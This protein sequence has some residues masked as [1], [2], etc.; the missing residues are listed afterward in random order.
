MY[1]HFKIK[2]RSIIKYNENI[3]ST[4]S[5]DTAQNAIKPIRKCWLKIFT[6]KKMRKRKLNLLKLHLQLIFKQPFNSLPCTESQ[7]TIVFNKIWAVCPWTFFSSKH[8]LRP[9]IGILYINRI[10]VYL[11]WLM[12]YLYY[13]LNSFFYV[14]H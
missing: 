2:L 3:V 8:H 10:A 13:L 7:Q 11:L 1:K 4:C 5:I 12:M 6:R 9:Y 14:V